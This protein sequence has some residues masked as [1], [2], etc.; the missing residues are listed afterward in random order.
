V[1]TRARYES[2]HAVGSCGTCHT[3]TDQIG[4]GL[5]NF[6]GIGVYRTMEAGKSIDSSGYI[7]DL[8]HATFTGPEDLARKLARR[9]RSR[10]ASPLR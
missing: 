6:D 1:T 2:Q 3:H 10:S 7:E 5:E 9:P 8:N 4:F